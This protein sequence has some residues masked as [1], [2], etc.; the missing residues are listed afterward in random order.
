MNVRFQADADLNHVIVKAMLRREPNIDFQTAHAAGLVGLR[1]P[2]VLA[3]A[4][5]AG[6]VL[7]THDRKTISHGVCR[8]SI[9][10]TRPV[11]GCT[12]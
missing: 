10:C 2:E 5:D 11:R 12:A 4:A 7:V 1:D 3:R 6:R 8:L 9:G